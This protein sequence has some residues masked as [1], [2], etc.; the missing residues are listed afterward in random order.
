MY[1]Y[2]QYTASKKE[3]PAQE[4]DIPLNAMYGMS[5]GEN[6]SAIMAASSAS[7]VTITGV[8]GSKRNFIV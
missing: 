5:D 2:N 3:D 8:F 1:K 7:A 4:N 6:Q